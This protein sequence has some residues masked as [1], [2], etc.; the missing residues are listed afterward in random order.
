MWHIQ[1]SVVE[2]LLCD[3]C[4]IHHIQHLWLVSQV[5]VTRVTGILVNIPMA[6]LQHHLNSCRHRSCLTRPQTSPTSTRYGRQ[7]DAQQHNIQTQHVYLKSC[8]LMSSFSLHRHLIWVTQ[9]NPTIPCSTGCMDLP[10]VNCYITAAR[11]TRADRRPT[12]TTPPPAVT[13]TLRWPLTP[14]PIRRVRAAR[15]FQRPL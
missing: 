11:P 7:W 8:T 10:A 2:T 3:I 6:T 9:I 12:S 4:Q 5:T 13:C 1:S 14:R 15:T